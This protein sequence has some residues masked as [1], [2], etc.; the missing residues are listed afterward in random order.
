MDTLTTDKIM[1][2]FTKEELLGIESVLQTA[3]T[4]GAFAHYGDAPRAAFKR[5][6]A[7]AKQI[8]KESKGS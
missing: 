6:K 1:V 2:E 5:L 8:E 7:L 3:A 4:M